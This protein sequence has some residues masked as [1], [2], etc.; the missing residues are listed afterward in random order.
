MTHLSN[1][2]QVEIVP[3]GKHKKVTKANLSEYIQSVVNMR[4]NESHKQMKAI[5]E[6]VSFVLPLNIC[7]MLTW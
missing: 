4:L 2:N 1:G 5:R 7:S 6:G 3:G